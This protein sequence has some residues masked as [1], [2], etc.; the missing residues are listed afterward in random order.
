MI[1]D[2]MPRTRVNLRSPSPLM[3]R[4]AAASL[5]AAVAGLMN[6]WTFQRAGSFATVQSGNIVSA[7]YFAAGGDGRRLGTVLMSI[8]AFAVGAAVCA[9]VVG[10]LSHAGRP[11]SPLILA[12]EAVLVAALVPLSQVAPALWVAVAVSAVA[13]VQGNAFHRDRGMLYG[14]TAVTFVLQSTAS[15]LGRALI[16]RKAGD[17]EPHL[18]PAGVYALVLLAFAGGGAGGFLADSVWPAA[19]LAVAATLLATMGVLTALWRRGPVDPSQNAPT[20]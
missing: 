6:A 4:P 16:A 9:V 18:R 2:G 11:Y 14:N 13:G 19:S 12:A 17:G 1:H 7:G 15:L 5:L 8:V 3:E 20:P 10:L